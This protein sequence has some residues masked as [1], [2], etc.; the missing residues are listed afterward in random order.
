[1]RHV[2]GFCSWNGL[3]R[4][5]AWTYGSLTHVGL[6]D[7][8]PHEAP[9]L[10]HRLDYGTSGSTAGCDSHLQ[11]RCF[12]DKGHGR[13]TFYKKIAAPTLHTVI[14][15]SGMLPCLPRR[16]SADCAEPRCSAAKSDLVCRAAGG[17]AV[18]WQELCFEMS[19][20]ETC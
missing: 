15:C 17:V 3:L 13:K 20:L 16:S 11:S 12:S 18:T 8:Y 4:S 1:M 7:A 10:C 9:R 6:A 19:A 14:T 2:L 5:T